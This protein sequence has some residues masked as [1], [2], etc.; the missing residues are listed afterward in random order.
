M[1]YSDKR[2]VQALLELAYFHGIRTVVFSPGSRNAPLVLAFQ[3]DERFEKVIIADERSAAFFALGVIQER[4]EPV[5]VCCTSGSAAANY[6]PAVVEAFYQRLPLVLLTA[7]RPKEWVDQGEGQTIRQ[8]GLYREHV[9]AEANLLVDSDNNADH[10]YNDRILNEALSMAALRE[11]PVHVNL[12]F[13]EPLYGTTSEKILPKTISVVGGRPQLSV[14][15]LQSVIDIWNQPVKKWVLVGQVLPGPQWGEAILELAKD[16]NTLI[17]T[18]STTNLPEEATI[19]H[20]DRV[21]NTITEEQKAELVPDVLLTFGGAIISKMVKSLLRNNP[22]KTHIHIDVKWPQPD[23]FRALTH[24]VIARPEEFFHHFLPQLKPANSEYREHWMGI[25][26][27]RRELHSEFENQAPFSDFTIYR[28]TLKAIPAHWKLQL[29]NSSVIR[30]VQLFD[31]GR[32]NLH[33]SNRGTAGIDGASSTAVGMA[34]ASE[35]PVLLIT[36][37]VS[38]FYDSNAFFNHVVPSSMRILLIHNGGGGIFRIIKGPSGSPALE[39]YFE[40]QHDTNAEGIAMSYGLDYKWAEGES[41]WM[42]G[43][44][45]LLEEGDGPRLLEV[46]T[47][48]EINAEVLQSY[49]AHLRN[50]VKS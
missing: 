8:E 10:A 11:G 23:T 46:H 28:D 22:P 19:G 9:V 18:E 3:A 14:E 15:E 44:E 41:N 45:W 27:R 39:E 37:D 50:G 42:P 24:G 21:I 31:G 7:D 35:D 30:Y 5:A 17:W 36:G 16:Q 47:P 2:N 33:F 4:R 6:L 43:L 26:Q 32:E 49:F 48:G 40:T 29:A 20:I 1:N 13:E 25:A 12:P 38:F 34:W